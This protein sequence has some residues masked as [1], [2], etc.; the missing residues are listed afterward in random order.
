MYRI[1]YFLLLVFFFI[2]IPGHS[3]DVYLLVDFVKDVDGDTIKVIHND[4]EENIRLE[5]IDCFETSKNTRAKW[6]SNYYNI[7]IGQVIKKGKKSKEILEDLLENTKKLY[8][9]AENRDRYGRLL[10]EMYLVNRNVER[11][12]QIGLNI[13]DYMLEQGLCKIYIP[14]H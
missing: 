3:A 12:S 4:K 1:L 14:R 13:N 8:L 6:Q 7:Q 5:R 10:G 11:G 2:P 9:N